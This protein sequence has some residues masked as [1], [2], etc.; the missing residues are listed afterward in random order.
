MIWFGS[1]ES[2]VSCSPT[3]AYSVLTLFSST[4]CIPDTPVP[5]PEIRETCW[6]ADYSTIKQQMWWRTDRLI[7]KLK[8]VCHYWPARLC[9]VLAAV[10]SLLCLSWWWLWWLWWLVWVVCVSLLLQLV[11]LSVELVLLPRLL[12]AVVLVSYP[13]NR[14]LSRVPTPLSRVLGTCEEDTCPS[15]EAEC[16]LD[17]WSRTLLWPGRAQGTPE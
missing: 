3:Q 8:I 17:W 1:K 4:A 16:C 12:R 15:C 7:I 10:V 13:D 14:P 9:L 2:S 5:G 6:D 11:K